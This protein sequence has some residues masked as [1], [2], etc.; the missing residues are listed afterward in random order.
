[1]KIAVVAPSP[2]PFAIGGAEKLWWGLCTHLNEHT[3]HQADL[4]KLP[5]PE[6]D[7]PS[8]LSSYERFTTLDLTAFDL[9]VTG[10]YPAWMVTHPRHVVYMLHRLRGLYDAYP[11]AAELPPGLDSDARVVALRSFMRRH[12]GRR[13][14][15]TEFFERVREI[16]AAAYTLPGALD[17]PGPFARELIHWLDGIGLAADA[18]ERYGAISHTVAARPG[19][20]PEGVDVHVAWPPP[21]VAREPGTAREHFFTVSRL[22]GPKRMDLV[23][24]AMQHVRAAVPLLIAGTGPDEA[25]LRELAAADPRIHLLGFQSDQRIA[26]LYGSA[27]AVPFAPYQE[28]YGLIAVEAMQAGK[29]VVTTQDAGGPCE[30]VADGETGFVCVPT[31]EAMGAAMQRLADDAALAEAMGAAGRRRAGDVTWSAVVE[32]LIVAEPPQTP[33]RAVAGAKATASATTARRLVVVST[34][35][36][37]P[38]RHGGQSRIYNL[39]RSLGPDYETVVISPCEPGGRHEEREIAPGVREIRIP[40]SAAH[41]EREKETEREIGLP[42]TDIVMAE[43]IELTP[44]FRAVVEREAA[45]AFALVASHP[46][47]FPVLQGLGL[48]I[49]YEAHNL[50]WKLKQA[51]LGEAGEG[52]RLRD[53]VYAVER[54]CARAAELIV[55]A[56]ASDADDLVDIYGVERERITLAPNGTDCSRIRYADIAAREELR[57]RMGLVG[58]R[59]LMFMGSGHWPNIEAVRRIFQ[60]AEAMP[61]EAFVIAGSVCYAFAADAKPPNL[62]FLG[63]IDDVTRNLVLELCDVALNPMEHGSGTNLK[64]LDFFAAGIP[65]VTT[66]LGARGIAIEDGRE[67]FIAEIPDFQKATQRLLHADAVTIDAMTARARS[68]VEDEF[69]WAVIAARLEAE[70]E[71]RRVGRGEGGGERK[72]R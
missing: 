12:A 18:V 54:D 3:A 2:S 51:I 8:L 67:A 38:P 22:D 45:G 33:Q 61:D 70:V 68:L 23:I 42:V 60:L 59:M 58:Q 35:G 57:Q 7:L 28:D 16:L 34:F 30:L 72:T 20:F 63:E 17:F 40:K 62:L 41:Q 9:V 46:Y 44:E 69:D 71:R 36:I 32:A 66:P 64:M 19:Y 50:E 15:L 25:R 53:A 49:W 47:L 4:I 27:I 13:S 37:Y 26:E 52:K 48:P 55:C 11:G 1:M 6:G 21:H 24:A 29:P 5:S 65:V 39:Y 43:L 10:K 56:A 14:A 31:P